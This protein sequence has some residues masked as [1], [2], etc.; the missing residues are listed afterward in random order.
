MNGGAFCKTIDSHFTFEAGSSVQVDDLVDTFSKSS[1]INGD[2]AVVGDRVSSQSAESIDGDGAVV[3]DEI[4]FIINI[5]DRNSGIC[6][7]QGT[8]CING[9]LLNVN[10]RTGNGHCGAFIKLDA[11]AGADGKFNF[12]I[13]DGDFSTFSDHC[14]NLCVFG[15]FNRDTTFGTDVRNHIIRTGDH[16]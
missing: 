7:L 6:Q 1:G 10:H 11:I 15:I 9:H 13:G 8:C 4:D 14:G 3:G 5:V 2:G 16:S 12:R